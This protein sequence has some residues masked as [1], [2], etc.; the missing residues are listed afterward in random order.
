MGR[1]EELH[2]CKRNCTQV[3][4]E[5]GMDAGRGAHSTNTGDQKKMETNCPNSLLLLLFRDKN[6]E[7]QHTA[8]EDGSSI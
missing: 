8:I 2:L 6:G 1:A 7:R 4:A 3:E 5:M